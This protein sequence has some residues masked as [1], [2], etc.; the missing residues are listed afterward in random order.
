LMKDDDSGSE[1]CTTF[2]ALHDI[3]K[4]YVPEHHPN[5]FMSLEDALRNVGM[6]FQT[7]NETFRSIFWERLDD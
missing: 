5:P 7:L 4:E 6:S 1:I 2:T 3:P